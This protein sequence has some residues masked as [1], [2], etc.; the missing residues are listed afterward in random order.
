MLAWGKT[1]AVM[2]RGGQDRWVPV[3]D[4]IAAIGTVV[5]RLCDGKGCVGKRVWGLRMI[6]GAVKER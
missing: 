3:A 2:L 1:N 5:V 6:G 4:C